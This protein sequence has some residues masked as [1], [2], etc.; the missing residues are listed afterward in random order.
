VFYL[1]LI[2]AIITVIYAVYHQQY[3]LIVPV[4]LVLFIIVY[5]DQYSGLDEI[6]M[7]YIKEKIKSFS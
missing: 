3:F 7:D 4:L 5:G 6:S 2:F 1:A